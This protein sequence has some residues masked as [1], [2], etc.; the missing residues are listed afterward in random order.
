ML[1]IELIKPKS[2]LA[3]VIKGGLGGV[4]RRNLFGD[5]GNSEISIY[6]GLFDTG[7]ILAHELG[8]YE[9]SKNRG[10]WR[11]WFSCLFGRDEPQCIELERKFMKEGSIGFE[12]KERLKIV[13][14]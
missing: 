2:W 13:I 1:T 3:K 7:K 5:I 4:F 14:R 8:H 10:L 9:L 12:I 11:R 6:L